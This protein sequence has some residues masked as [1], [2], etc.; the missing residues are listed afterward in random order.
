MLFR[1]KELWSGC[2]NSLNSWRRK[3]KM[4]KLG[5]TS[6]HIFLNLF[7]AACFPCVKLI[8][9]FICSSSLVHFMLAEEGKLLFLAYWELHQSSSFTCLRNLHP[10]VQFWFHPGAKLSL[11]CWIPDCKNPTISLDLNNRLFIF[12]VPYF[13]GIY[14]FLY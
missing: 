2:L 8:S 14:Y 4:I 13:L 1:V 6:Q 11:L 10:S 9:W 7:L 12:F 5:K 3:E